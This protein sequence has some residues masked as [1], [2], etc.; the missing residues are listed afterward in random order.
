MNE[1]TL[2]TYMQ[3]NRKYYK[4]NYKLNH[5]LGISRVYDCKENYIIY[6]T[7]HILKLVEHNALSFN[8]TLDQA[9]RYI[10]NCIEKE[11]LES[12]C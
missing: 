10:I 5:N 3:V 4:D 1:I 2:E 6:K 11:L 8:G 9:R 12:E 7:E